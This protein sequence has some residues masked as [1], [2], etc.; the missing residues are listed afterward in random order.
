MG[1]FNITAGARS[2]FLKL[3][4]NYIPIKKE[5]FQYKGVNLRVWAFYCY[6]KLY[7]SVESHRSDLSVSSI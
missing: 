4:L 6:Q 1:Y 2:A 3:M 7:P 5:E